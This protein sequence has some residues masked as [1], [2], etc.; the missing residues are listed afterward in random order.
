MKVSIDD[1]RTCLTIGELV[2]GEAFI[3]RTKYCGDSIY[4]FVTY[5]HHHDVVVLLEVS[6]NGMIPRHCHAREV[7]VWA[8]EPLEITGITF[9]PSTVRQSLGL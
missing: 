1:K 3:H 4:I 7:D 5:Q 2:E 8:I 9:E 6:E